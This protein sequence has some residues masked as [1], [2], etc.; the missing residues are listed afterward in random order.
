M[1]KR[2][3]AIVCTAALLFSMAAVSASA[4]A[5]WVKYDTPSDID[6][7]FVAFGDMQSITWTDNRYG[8]TYVKSAFDWILNNKDSRKIEY[9]FGLG[10]TIDTLTTYSTNVVQGNG[11]TQN[12]N[13]WILVSDQFHRLDGIIPYTVTRGN[14]DDEGGYHKY[15]CTEAYKEQMTGFYYDPE[16]PATLGN[17]MA[18]HYRKITIGGVRYLMLSL[19]YNATTDVM[20]WANE[21]IMANPSYRVIVSIHA[22]LNGYNGSGVGK[23]ESSNN[24]FLEGSIGAANADNSAQ[25]NTKFDGEK[26]WTNV[27]SK[28]ENMFMILCGHD[29]I[30]TPVHNVRTG[31]YGNQVIEILTDTS[32]YDLEMGGS[33]YG[34]NLMMI[35]N[36][37]EDTNEIQIEYFSP[38]RS[39]QGETKCHLANEQITFTYEDLS[40]EK[41]TMQKNASVRI[42]EVK[43]GLR[44]TSEISEETVDEL[45]NTYG[46]DNVAVGTLIAPKDKL[47]SKALTHEFGTAGVDYLD[48]VGKIDSPFAKEDGKLV[49]AGS[50]SNIKME[51]LGRVFSGVGYIAYRESADSEWIY[52]YCKTATSKSIDRVA[53]SA[54]SD[55]TASYTEAELE[56]IKKLTLEYYE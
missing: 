35:L 10:D 30:P 15:I 50:I 18:N 13:E 8:T 33:N 54:L 55:K 1:K 34:A 9:V 56:I 49:Y 14:H 19:D 29:A 27:F 17:S 16:Q 12:V 37:R 31:I 4:L 39:A 45:I 22:Y 47:G 20:N 24:G 52:L 26:L 40:Y 41:P 21:V 3:I 11:K 25:V 46:A 44:F 42:S 51:N 23:L 48:V 38:S 6:Y 43:P 36:F 28:H 2:I 32:K 5:S 7:S 53:T